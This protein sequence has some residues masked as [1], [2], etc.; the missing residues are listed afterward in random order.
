MG[1]AYGTA[2]AGIGITGMGT[3]RPELIMKVGRA[4]QL[5]INGSKKIIAKVIVSTVTDSCRVSGNKAHPGLSESS[6][7]GPSWIAWL[8]SSRFTA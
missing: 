3:Q 2:K 5:A 7:D 4:M 1:A 6:I 8:V